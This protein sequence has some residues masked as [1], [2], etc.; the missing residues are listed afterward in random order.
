[1]TAFEYY[2]LLSKFIAH[3]EECEGVSYVPFSCETN[4]YDKIVFTEKEL[5]ILKEA[6]KSSKEFDKT[7]G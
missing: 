3:V 5:Q 6:E 7:K 4:E 2:L 1:M